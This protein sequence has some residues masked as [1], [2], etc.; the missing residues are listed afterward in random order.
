MW[1]S[2]ATKTGAAKRDDARAKWKVR[3]DQKFLITWEN[4]EC[5]HQFEWRN[6]CLKSSVCLDMN[7]RAH[8][9]KHGYIYTFFRH[10]YELQSPIY[11]ETG[12]LFFNAGDL[13]YEWTLQF[14]LLWQNS[15]S[16]GV[17]FR[18][19]WSDDL[20]LPEALVFVCSRYFCTWDLSLLVAAHHPPSRV[21]MWSLKLSP[22]PC[23]C[24]TC[25]LPTHIN[26]PVKVSAQMID[27]DVFWRPARTFVG[28][29]MVSYLAYWL[30]SASLGV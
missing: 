11:W 10:N 24:R 21:W 1:M 22:G 7:S 4:R 3:T 23:L 6:I 26:S 5:I 17:L 14:H 30:D 9:A 19:W 20:A 13:W 25:R 28:G 18:W 29:C 2:V 16:A 12:H 15:H 27:V 8:C